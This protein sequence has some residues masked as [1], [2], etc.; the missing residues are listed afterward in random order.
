M[1]TYSDILRCKEDNSDLACQKFIIA[2]FAES[3][4]GE[5]V[6]LD[7]R[8]DLLPELYSAGQACN[9]PSEIGITET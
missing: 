6:G 5:I 7:T 9:V 2:V 3:S 1:H 4:L 8:K